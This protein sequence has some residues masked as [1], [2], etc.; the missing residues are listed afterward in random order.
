MKGLFCSLTSEDVHSFLAYGLYRQK[1]LSYGCD[2]ELE[3]FK[4]A[5]Y[6]Y[7]LPQRYKKQSEASLQSSSK[8]SAAAALAGGQ[9]AH[10]PLHFSRKIYLPN[11]TTR[12]LED[13]H[14]KISTQKSSD[15]E[16]DMPYLALCRVL[17]YKTYE[18]KGS[19]TD[20]DVDFAMGSDYD[21]VHSADW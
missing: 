1:K 17:L 13:T 20:A 15:H 10:A 21:S 14:S 3:V 9:R 19:I 5:W 16:L 12:A 11:L 18:V 8:S 4:R 7:P 2:G 6:S